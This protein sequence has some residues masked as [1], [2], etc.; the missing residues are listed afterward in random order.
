M[1]FI[2]RSTDYGFKWA[3]VTEQILT[4]YSDYNSKEPEEKG[5]V[6]NQI[7]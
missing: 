1:G 3:N 5:Y 2:Y 4:N 7:L 6:V